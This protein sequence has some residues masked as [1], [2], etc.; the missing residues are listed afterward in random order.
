MG[1][2]WGSKAFHEDKQGKI[3]GLG[4]LPLLR[5]LAL[6]HTQ[7]PVIPVSTNLSHV[8]LH[9][10]P[11]ACA[12]SAAPPALWSAHLPSLTLSL[13][14]QPTSFLS[15]CHQSMGH[16]V[17]VPRLVHPFAGA[18]GTFSGIVSHPKEIGQ[19]WAWPCLSTDQWLLFEQKT[20]Y[21]PGQV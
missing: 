1:G 7:E 19:G 17:Q 6:S 20:P 5:R 13:F 8:T 11:P 21:L 9:E 4:A 14:S 18:V 10:R 15:P 2:N 12:P 3:Q 16:P